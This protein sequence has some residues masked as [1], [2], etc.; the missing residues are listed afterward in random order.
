MTLLQEQPGAEQSGY[1]LGKVDPRSSED[2]YHQAL[3]LARIYCPEWLNAQQSELDEQD[4]GIVLL[5]LFTQLCDTV[6]RRI[7]QL[8]QKQLL[9]FYQFLGLDTRL[10]KPARVLLSFNL[11]KS[12][13]EPILIPAGVQVASAKDQKIVYETTEPLRASNFG[14]VAAYAVDP[15]SDSTLD[16]TDIVV[17]KQQNFNILGSNLVN[18]EEQPTPNLEYLQHSMML[19][20]TYFDYQTAAQLVLAIQFD[21][22]P[23]D[24]GKTKQRHSETQAFF[25]WFG[26][27]DKGKQ[28]ELNPKLVWQGN[29]LSVTFNNL[30]LY[31]GTVAGQ[32]ANYLLW[33]LDASALAKADSKIWSSVSN[34]NDS[35]D[36]DSPA[37]SVGSDSSKKTDNDSG[38]LGLQ[39]P[40]IGQITGLHFSLSAQ[41]VPWDALFVNSSQVSAKK[42][43]YIFG[44]NPAPKDVFYFASKEAFKQGFN[45][46]LNLLI[47]PGLPNKSLRLAWQFFDG[48]QWQALPAYNWIKYRDSQ[49][50]ETSWQDL[51]SGTAFN[52]DLPGIEE[53]E[54]EINFTCP[55]IGLAKINDVESRWIRVQI[56]NGDYGDRYTLTPLDLEQQQQ[57]QQALEGKLQ[58]LA[59]EWQDSVIPDESEF[60][61]KELMTLGDFN[62][63]DHSSWINGILGGLF[64]FGSKAILEKLMG[65]S[66]EALFDYKSPVKVKPRSNVLD[67]SGLDS[68]SPSLNEN[69]QKFLDDEITWQKILA[70][71]AEQEWV[72]GSKKNCVPPYMSAFTL[73]YSKEKAEVEHCISE[74]NFQLRQGLHPPFYPFYAISGEPSLFLGFQGD[75]S[76]LKWNGYF[77]FSIPNPSKQTASKDD[78]GVGYQYYSEDG[79][80]TLALDVDQTDNLTR[81]GMI[82]WHLPDQEQAEQ[83]KVPAAQMN[84]LFSCSSPMFW[85]RLRRTKFTEKSD[86][87]TKIVSSLASVAASE[88]QQNNDNHL[89]PAEVLEG[90]QVKGI[91]P[92]SVWAE[93]YTTHTNQVL[94]TSNQ[95]ENQQ[96]QI[97]PSL[98]YPGQQIEVREMTWPV[99]EQVRMIELESGKGAIHEVVNNGHKEVWVRWA[100]VPSLQL[101]GPKSRHYMIDPYTGTIT[102]GDGVR[103]MIPPTL[104]NNIVA[105]WYQRSH[106]GQTMPGA[107]ELTKLLR[108]L[109]NVK[110]V[111]NYE[112]A[113]GKQTQELTSDFLARAPQVIQTRDRAVTLHDFQFLAMQSTNLVARAKCC[114]EETTPH[115]IEVIIVPDS[116][117]GSYYPGADLSQKVADYLQQRALPTLKSQ[118]MI[119]APSYTRITVAAKLTIDPDYTQA[120]V[121]SAV[122]KA[123]QQFLDPV[124]G[125]TDHQ[126]W[127]F[128]AVVFSSQVSSVIRNVDGVVEILNTAGVASV[129]SVSA[130]TEV[131]MDN[132]EKAEDA[133]D[134]DLA[135]ADSSSDD[136]GSGSFTQVHLGER[137]LP[138]PGEI[139]ITF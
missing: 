51:P 99:P 13:Q 39:L 133:E 24:Q 91:Y 53:A 81:S 67:Y 112:A 47:N 22:V 17:G 124:V 137:S 102:F 55:D 63:K 97:S 139:N 75:V 70:Y 128:G 7:N 59:N 73:Q 116:H 5:K 134:I 34:S 41:N 71:L 60:K 77:S 127:D 93:D 35:P 16:L 49:S 90:I 101:S 19:S 95:T 26:F 30:V 105:R 82:A 74:N 44:N 68:V 98:V 119:R 50:S 88:P 83:R 21:R 23:P 111:T 46:T 80:Q 15:G 14:L 78:Y 118:I 117:Y 43:F 69:M 94:G 135:E 122:V 3:A 66:V 138:L 109:A 76:Q 121:R 42:G 20:S 61:L 110:A 52:F 79:W 64:S 108:N 103:G 72:V 1:Q 27:D 115:L 25:R 29:E 92:N 86:D 131:S 126:G 85:V 96:F 136:L 113:I 2:I 107:G 37:D 56:I 100:A 120:S 11:D 38:P 87:T 54:V 32:T 123:L 28:I 45:V 65:S 8:P 36:P 84:T 58:Q 48:L 6:S 130:F 132:S 114:Q 40:M 62:H 10:P 104:K 125:Q 9:S 12:V 129:A 106:S 18:T 31:P 89:V 33:T 4:L 57:L